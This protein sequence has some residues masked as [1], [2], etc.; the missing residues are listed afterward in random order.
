MT[1]T[2]FKTVTMAAI[3]EIGTRPSPKGTFPYSPPTYTPKIILIV[4]T[5]LLL[6]D[7]NQLLYGQ[8]PTHPDRQTD[9]QTDI[10]HDDNTPPAHMGL[11]G[12]KHTES[13]NH[14][15]LSF[16]PTITGL[17]IKVV[18]SFLVQEGSTFRACPL[19]LRSPV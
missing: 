3:F 17:L 11:R 5:V 14:C 8:T 4:I 1:E 19:P 7:G 10:A 12:K 6:I 9:R 13:L 2:N 18:V 15:W 16:Q